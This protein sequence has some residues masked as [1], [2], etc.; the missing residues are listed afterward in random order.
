MGHVLT[1]RILYKSH[2]QFTPLFKPTYNK[3]YKCHV[4]IPVCIICSTTVDD[5]VSHVQLTV[6]GK[7]SDYLSMLLRLACS[8]TQLCQYR[9]MY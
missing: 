5:L 8:Q 3:L 1:F 2:I 7:I 9:C 4:Y 6:N